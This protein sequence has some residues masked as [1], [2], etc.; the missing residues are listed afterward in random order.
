[1]ALPFAESYWWVESPFFSRS[2][3]WL[4]LQKL[5]SCLSSLRRITKTKG[6]RAPTCT[7]QKRLVSVIPPGEHKVSKKLQ[8]RTERVRYDGALCSSCLTVIPKSDTHR[9]LS[10]EHRASHNVSISTLFHFWKRWTALS[11]SFPDF[12]FR[13]I[14]SVLYYLM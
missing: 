9:P 3:L 1:M 12:Q 11:F 5:R 13:R 2:S 6:G 10:S 8:K 7:S 4:S 14:S